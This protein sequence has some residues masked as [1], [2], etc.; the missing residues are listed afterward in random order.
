MPSFDVLTIGSATQD[1]FLRSK[2]FEEVPDKNAPDGYDVLFPFGAKINV[3]DIFTTTGG[4]ATNAA[5]TLAR[6]GFKTACLTRI[7]KDQAGDSAIADLK[8]DKIATSLVQID[9]EHKTDH[10]VIL[11]SGTGHRAILS[12]RDAS[13]HLDTAAVPWNK[14]SAKWVYIT[15]V[16]ANLS[17]LHDAFAFAK[18]V[19]ARIAWNPGRAELDLGIDHLQ[20]LLSQTAVL[21]LNREEAA[22]LS[23]KPPEWLPQIIE[24]LSAYPTE[25]LVITDGGKGAYVHASQKT[26]FAPALDVKRVNT[27]GAGDAF[28]SGFV[29]AYARTSDIKTALATGLLNATGV[30][31]HMG[32]KAGIL[33]SPPTPSAIK[34]V[35]VEEILL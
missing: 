10:S 31:C 15:S 16:A 17:L 9:P 30:V 33:K 34:K 7:G 4:G 13:A 6:F 28:G 27:T 29:A 21:I 23:E 25:A 26:W 5:V 19:N 11:L 1:I 22:L 2:K 12:H 20:G 18:R 3:D 32:A 24:R 35:N 8:R 14:L